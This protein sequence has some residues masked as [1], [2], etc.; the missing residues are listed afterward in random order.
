MLFSV[1][2]RC[3]TAGAYASE[4]AGR[5]RVRYADNVNRQLHLSIV[6]CQLSIAIQKKIRE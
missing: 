3:L 2:K 4:E 5:P 6:S 1:E